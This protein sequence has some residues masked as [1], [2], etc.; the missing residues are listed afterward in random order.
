MAK[1]ILIGFGKNGDKVRTIQTTQK[2]KRKIEDAI[3]T[4]NYYRNEQV[5]TLLLARILET[6]DKLDFYLKKVFCDKTVDTNHFRDIWFEA[7][8]LS[9]RKGVQGNTEGGT[10]LDLAFGDVARRNNYP[11]GIK[12]ANCQ[13]PWVCF[14]EAKLLSDCSLSVSCDL[15][16]NQIIRVIENLLCF[17][18]DLKY[19]EKL[20]FTLLTPRFFRDNKHA[21]LYGYKIR[22]YCDFEG[23][24]CI[25][26][27]I[28]DIDRLTIN[29]RNEGNWRYPENLEERVGSLKINWVTYEEIFENE[30]GLR[31]KSLDL[32]DEATLPPLEE[33][34]Q[35]LKDWL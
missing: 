33:K 25:D 32:T 14:V 6:S 4:N 16:R 20:F 8:P 18:N 9:P 26:K 27:I 24:A 3:E 31:A 28:H 34:I 22:E 5:W 1:E 12:Y 2:Q 17:Q 15:A 30:Y 21:R 35:E 29:R 7:I 13:N 23:N 10:R 19:P 11:T